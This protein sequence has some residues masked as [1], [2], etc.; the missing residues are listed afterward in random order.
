LPESLERTLFSAAVKRKKV[1]A[2]V[3]AEEMRVMSRE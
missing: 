1:K 2:K 3:E